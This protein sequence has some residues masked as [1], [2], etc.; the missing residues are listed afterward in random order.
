[1]STPTFPISPEL[2][3]PLALRRVR[4]GHVVLAG[5][6]LLIDHGR[7]VPDY[8]REHLHDLLN[9]GH[10]YLGEERAGWAQWPVLATESGQRLHAKLEELRTPPRRQR[11][12]Q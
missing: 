2:G 5:N 1:V 12:I 9:D 7:R 6:G 11:T 10:L 8:I 3:Q 4:R